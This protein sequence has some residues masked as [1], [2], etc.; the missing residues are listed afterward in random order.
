MS[1][2]FRRAARSM[3]GCTLLGLTALTLTAMARP[4]VAS[5]NQ[6]QN[7]FGLELFQK[8]YQQSPDKNLFMSPTSIYLALAMLYNGAAGQ[9][10]IEMAKVLHIEGLSLDELNLAARKWLQQLQAKDRQIVLEIANAIWIRQGFDLQADYITAIQNSFQATAHEAPFNQDTLKQ[11]NGWVDK[12]THGKITKILDQLEPDLT[13]VLL[14]AI[15]FKGEWQTAFDPKQTHDQNFRLD[16]GQEKRVSLMQRLGK[17]DYLETQHFQIVRLPYG[18]N[19]AADMVLFLPTDGRSLKAVM[20]ELNPKNWQKWQ[21]E[22][23]HKEGAVMLPRFKM[24][25]TQLLNEPLKAM[26]MPSVFGQA[27]FTHMAKRSLQVSYVLHKSFV[28]VNEKGTEAAAVTAIGMRVT[29]VNPNPP[30]VFK[31]D[32]PFAFAIVD[33]SHNDLLFLGALV[34]PS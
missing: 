28:E 3:I 15:Y 13:A 25:Y 6:A 26:G 23:Q 14:N 32:H 19:K 18:K 2:I 33:R 5:L 4:P 21:T 20:P 16:S 30:F 12:N 11:I 17:F 7:N 8:L 1:H 22:F 31:A 29:S 34:N 24:E 9:T 10:Q 27:N